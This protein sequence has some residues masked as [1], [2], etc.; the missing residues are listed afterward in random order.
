MSTPIDDPAP[1]NSGV[2]NPAPFAPSSLVSPAVRKKSES[3]L[4]RDILLGPH[5]R[6]GPKIAQTHLGVDQGNAIGRHL[7]D[8][9]WG[10]ANLGLL[11]EVKVGELDVACGVEEDVCG[12]VVVVVVS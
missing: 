9:R 2:S 11:G 3:S 7:F 10:A 1:R 5:K 8:A 6:I 4:G 12:V